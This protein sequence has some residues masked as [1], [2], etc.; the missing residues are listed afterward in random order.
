MMINE[1]NN[2]PH[3]GEILISADEIDKMARRCAK[4]IS[5][6]YANQQPILL[7]VLKGAALWSTL[8]TRYLTIQ[9]DLDFVQ[10][11]SYSGTKKSDMTKLVNDTDLDVTDRP[12]IIMDDIFET[13]LTIEFLK[14]HLTKRGARS[15][16]SCTLLDKYQHHDPKVFPKYLG[17]RIEDKWVIGF[18]MDLD[19][20]YRG[21]PFVAVYKD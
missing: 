11:A 2:D 4:E 14:T 9:A 17:T 21:L 18:G 3:L 8:V 15:I 16:E 12:V 5:N 7:S 20:K 10:V 19:G 13:G 1:F 6:D